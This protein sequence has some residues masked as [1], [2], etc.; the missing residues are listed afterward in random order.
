[1]LKKV[2]GL[3]IV[4]PI[5]VFLFWYFAIPDTY[6]EHTLEKR[7]PSLSIGERTL[8]VDI[9]GV[10]KSP[11]PGRLTIRRVSL[12]GEE[13]EKLVLE[14]LSLR[15]SLLSLI[16]LSPRGDVSSE[17]GGGKMSLGIL[18]E[19]GGV[20]VS[21]HL[22]D[23]QTEKISS[24]EGVEGGGILSAKGNL[25]YSLHGRGFE[26][27]LVFKLDKMSYKDIVRRDM[28]IPLSLFN[29]MTGEFKLKG[30]NLVPGVVNLK[31]EKIYARIRGDLKG[32]R[33]D[34]AIEVIPERGFPDALLIPIQRYMINR[35]YYKIPIGVDI[36]RLL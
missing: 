35:S 28:Y 7:I 24:V 31:G 29:T 32:G 19:D 14:N 3:I 16:L 34:G 26:G 6:I 1:M 25:T 17:V 13:I 15:I 4:L 2:I 27:T 22:K 9:S 8:S 11:V 12:K 23:V 20:R 36:K 5:L 33:F 21:L 10:R 18:A 30:G